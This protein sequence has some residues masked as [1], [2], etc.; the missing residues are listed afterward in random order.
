MLGQAAAV[1]SQGVLAK[2]SREGINLAICPKLRKF[3][4]YWKRINYAHVSIASSQDSN[5]KVHSVD[6]AFGGS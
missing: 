3:F 2:Y 5:F 1:S 6:S 4:F